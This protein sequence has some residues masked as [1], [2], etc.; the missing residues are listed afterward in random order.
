M[1][2]PLHSDEAPTAVPDT[3]H[4]LESSH[5]GVVPATPTVALTTADDD[6]ELPNLTQDQRVDTGES[7]SG[8]RTG[9]LSGWNRITR[10]PSVSATAVPKSASLQEHE[11]SSPTPSRHGEV[12]PQQPGEVGDEKPI[13]KVATETAGGG[14]QV[15]E[16][17]VV[18]QAIY[19]LDVF[20]PEIRP[21]TSVDII[22]VHDFDETPEDAWVM[23]VEPSPM[24][25]LNVGKAD[26]NERD[27]TSS[28]GPRDAQ[29][30]K[31]VDKKGKG[32]E[33]LNQTEGNILGDD[34]SVRPQK[35]DPKLRLPGKDLRGKVKSLEPSMRSSS[36]F[37]IRGRPRA[38]NWIRDF[39]P[40][41]ITD[42]RV[43]S[44]TYSSPTFEKKTGNWAEY[45]ESAAKALL[46]R[47][48]SSRQLFFQR[49]VPLVFIGSGFG[50]IIVQKAIALAAKQENAGSISLNDI[51]QVVFL[52]TPFP[53]PD[54][55]QST[56]SDDR[57]KSWFPKNTNVRMSRILLEI[58]T[59]EKD[60]ELVDD[61]WTEY[62]QSRKQSARVL[63]TSW[64]YSQARVQQGD[65]DS[66]SLCKDE[67]EYRASMTGITFTSVAIYRHRR[68]ARMGDTQDYIYRT[69]LAKIQS[70]VLYQAIKSGSV[71]LVETILDSKPSLIYKTESGR[72][73]L[74]IACLMEPPSETIVTL[75]IN[76]RPDD[77]TEPD[78]G[79]ATP[80][81]HA[82]FK[83][84]F[85]EPEEGRER[86]EYSG[87]I[88]YLMRNMQREDL[89]M[90]DNEDRSPWD[91]IC[92]D[93]TEYYC[94]CNSSECAATWIRELRENLE[95]I[96]GPA[97]TQDHAL[98]TEPTPP[99]ADSPQYIASFVA[100]GTVSEFYHT[101]NKKT[102]RVEE[103]INL[104]TPSVY[105][106]VYDSNKRCARIL[107]SSRR[108]GKENDFR[109]RWILLPANNA[110]SLCHTT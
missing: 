96:T 91:Y 26:G 58:E 107:E 11:Q 80:L 23:P 36:E 72:N 106:M 79:G 1:A 65:G 37:D 34:K 49:G 22:A 62:Q 52:D 95:P 63:E 46:E 86:S 88:R 60:S 104:K 43:L 102:K 16:P 67:D 98:P 94:S 109:C 77:T 76:E 93:S 97:I 59:R 25:L 57:F 27:R 75:L 66:M 47:V 83:A 30:G 15:D 39:L 54:E 17:P 81:H 6:L 13:V 24:R 69:I 99:T 18:S 85:N 55:P 35:A 82:V 7:G 5:S 8:R 21:R 2:S 61:V 45:V 42:S 70:T 64:L 41:D 105:E 90:R 84:W 29:R 56:G 32:P 74:H 44:F 20:P 87:V 101:T 9:L 4:R 100:E 73:P 50:G 92:E 53:E 89:D 78:E 38:V 3:S 31:Q 28:P 48:A 10:R 71:G 51:Y 110:S 19:S 103:Q 12:L 40:N 14:G 68:L 33:L 108:K